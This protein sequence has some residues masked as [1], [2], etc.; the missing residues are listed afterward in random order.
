MK[1]KIAILL[2]YKEQFTKKKS[3]AASIWVYDY[4]KRS[5]HNKATTVFGN[6]DKH[7]KPLI[8]NF[9][10]INLDKFI[11]KKNIRYTKIFFDKIYNTGYKIIE[12]HNRPESLL[13]ILN[14][15]KKFKTVFFFHNNPQELRGST[16]TTN[17]KFI[18][19]NTDQIYFVSSWVKKKF[20]DGL[21][22]DDKNN[23]KILYP[24]IKPINKFPHKKKY[25]IFTGKLNRSKGYDIYGKAILRI[26]NKFK[27]WK[28]YAIGNE[29]REKITF[30][31]ERFKSID[32]LPH[33]KILNFYKKSSISIVPSMW[34]EPFGRT[35][36][37]SA[38]Y[39]NATIVSNRGGLTETFKDPIVIS[40]IN[41]KKIELEVEKL[42]LNKSKLKKIQRYNFNNNLHN[43][44]NLTNELDEIKS[45]FLIDKPFLIKN[46]KYKIL[47]IG[48][49]GE[50]TNHRLFNISI[51]HKIS[52][53]LIRNGHDVINFSYRD[54][55]SKSVIN[56]LLEIDTKVNEIL[57]NYRPDLLLLGH[58]N[59]LQSKTLEKVKKQ[60]IKT[61]LWYEDHVAKTGPNFNNN[62]KLIEKNQEFID[63]Y[64]ITTHPDVV[65]TS[66]P[67]DKIN[68][69]PIP[70][71]PNIENLKI[72]EIKN[73]FKDLFFAL[74]HGVNF[75]TLRKGNLDERNVFAN[76]LIKKNI[77]N[78]FHF[79]GINEEQ[80]K[81]NYDY[82][83]ELSKCKMALNLS[84]G[85]PLKYASSNRISTLMANGIMTFIDIKTNYSDFFDDKEIA[86]YKNVNDLSNQ[87]EK[88]KG[89]I[90][91]I[92]KISRNGKKRYFQLFNNS[93]VSDFILHK[94]LKLKPNFKYIWNK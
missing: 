26:L 2:P 36:M 48:S 62:L 29:P 10:N 40:N 72:Y 30:T 49:F 45:F 6:L 46:K 9:I 32:W 75:G 90:N 94:T 37:E 59:I 16:T 54:Y 51:A 88:F 7:D 64:F 24:S 42:I 22:I 3:S 65:K 11:I 63:N 38:A 73:R 58:N 41:Q 39:G 12:I 34:E 91:L 83:L 61:G 71:D 60:N 50:K 5:K 89:N 23:C 85:K 19:E 77:N 56:K 1:K 81:W 68:F 70:A 14:K 28:A 87:I 13:Y 82:Y 27:D 79:L 53:G 33:S 25:I 74:S 43:I 47:H 8:K 84:R 55:T 44:T 67:K 66:I 92:N 93:I 69:M 15:T 20:F 17:R 78:N 35:A 76:E 21:I 57:N 80:P 52:S 86:F 4:L 31:H 18:L